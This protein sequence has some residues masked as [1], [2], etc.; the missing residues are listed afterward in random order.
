MARLRLPGQG[1]A[2][3]P[4]HMV[5]NPSW[6]A[7]VTVWLQYPLPASRLTADIHL[8]GYEQGKEVIAS[9]RFDRSLRGSF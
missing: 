8:P 2:F 4:V 9:E 6:K 7:I 3:R 1:E 5:D